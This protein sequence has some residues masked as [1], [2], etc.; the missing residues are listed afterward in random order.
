MGVYTSIKTKKINFI[1]IINL[2]KYYYEDLA[3]LKE[4]IV[5]DE[6]YLQQSEMHIELIHK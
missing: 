1:P 2:K 4:D 3:I 6:Y 5:F